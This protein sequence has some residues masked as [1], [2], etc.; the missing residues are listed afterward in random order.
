MKRCDDEIRSEVAKLLM[1]MMA[2][3]MMLIMSCVSNGDG[4]QRRFRGGLMK[5]GEGK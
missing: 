1:M 5:Y 4:S 3:V 2:M